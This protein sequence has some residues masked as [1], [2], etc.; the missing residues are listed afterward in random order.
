MSEQTFEPSNTIAFD[1]Y[2]IVSERGQHG[3]GT[4][5]TWESIEPFPLSKSQPDLKAWPIFLEE[6]HAVA[7][8]ESLKPWE[9]ERQV[10]KPVTLLAVRGTKIDVLKDQ[11]TDSTESEGVQADAI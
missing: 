1:V 2:A 8:Y 11:K 7:F 6:H 3:H 5:E 10:V 4:W 9:K